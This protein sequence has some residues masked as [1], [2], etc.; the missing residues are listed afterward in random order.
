MT[1]TKTQTELLMHQ[2][3]DENGGSMDG[4]LLLNEVQRRYSLLKKKTRKSK[5]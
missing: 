2:I 3:L 1:R 5:K 4:Q